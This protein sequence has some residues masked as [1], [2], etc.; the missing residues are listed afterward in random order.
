MLLELLGPPEL[1][2]IFIPF[3]LLELLGPPELLL[4]LLGPLELLV[5]FDVGCDIAV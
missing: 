4:E 3:M 1:L 2:L 5:L